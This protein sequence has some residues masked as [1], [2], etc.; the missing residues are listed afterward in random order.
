V[1]LQPAQ[2]LGD[3]PGSQLG[4]PTGAARSDIRLGEEELL[5]RLVLVVRAG[6]DSPHI[7]HRPPGLVAALGIEQQ[8][9]QLELQAPGVNEL[10]QYPGRVGRWWAGRGTPGGP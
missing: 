8:Q 2:G 3:L 1:L 7:A 9:L 5:P 4:R 10:G 6:R